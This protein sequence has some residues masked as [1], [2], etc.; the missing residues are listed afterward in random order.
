MN[1][2]FQ[3]SVDPIVSEGTLYACILTLSLCEPTPVGVRLRTFHLISALTLLSIHSPFVP[4]QE[5]NHCLH[6]PRCFLVQ[7][8]L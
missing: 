8:P 2:L 4:K 6:E 1:G 7:K 3:W 5:K